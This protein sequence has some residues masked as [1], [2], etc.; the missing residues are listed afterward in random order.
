MARATDQ[1]L[2]EQPA[3]CPYRKLNSNVLMVQSSEEWLGKDAANGLDRPRNRCILAQ[4]QVRA[5][6]VVIS[7]IRFE[8][9]AKMPL[10]KHNDIVQAIPPSRSAVPHIRF[11]MAIAPLSAGH[12]CPLPEGGG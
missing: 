11:A 5:S 10:A 3:S 6:L 2:S 9:V 4:R 8:Q 1:R 12:E 7:L